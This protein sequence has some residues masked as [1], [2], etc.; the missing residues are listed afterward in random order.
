M[1]SLERSIAR[2][3]ETE[4]EKISC[5][6]LGNL[7]TLGLQKWEAGQWLL[8][9]S[10]LDSI[11][12]GD[13]DAPDAITLAFTRYRVAVAGENLAAI[14]HELARLNVATLRELPPAYRLRVAAEAAFIS[15][16]VLTEVSPKGDRG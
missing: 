15:S 6:E 11:A 4:A 8:P 2:R 14:W 5:V 9:W 12:L 1:N 3:R 13:E 16:I 7:P 10:H